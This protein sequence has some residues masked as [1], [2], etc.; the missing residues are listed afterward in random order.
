ML[1]NYGEISI[2]RKAY[3]DYYLEA[4]KK[5]KK[6]VTLKKTED[7]DFMNV[8]RV[9]FE[10]IP[11]LEDKCLVLGWLEI[12]FEKGR[13][14]IIEQTFINPTYFSLTI[15]INIY[16]KMESFVLEKTMKSFTNKI[17]KYKE[18]TNSLFMQLIELN[19]NRLKFKN[20]DLRY[21]G[22]EICITFTLVEKGTKDILKR[23]PGENNR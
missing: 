8:A 23:S 9:R 6:L 3:K 4:I 1:K 7:S 5:N 2:I 17:E 22:S 20:D 19:E 15:T 18:I 10:M 14:E 16:T 12:M 13:L 21:L 11:E